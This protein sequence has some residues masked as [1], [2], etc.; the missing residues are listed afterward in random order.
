MFYQNIKS[1]IEIQD[2]MQL[3]K[4]TPKLVDEC[5]TKLQDL[6]A[7]RANYDK[8]FGESQEITKSKDTALLELLE[9]M[10]DFD[11]VAKV[12]LFDQPQLL[13]VLGIFVRS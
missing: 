3:I 6:M 7:K 9:W 1:N 4:I 5:L 8:E 2:K 12:A 13:E 10:E 11:A